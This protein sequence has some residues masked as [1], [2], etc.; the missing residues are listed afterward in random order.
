MLT[1]IPEMVALGVTHLWLPPPSQSVDD[2]G[3]LP[4]QLYNL[5]SKYG[6]REQ[7]VELCRALKAANIAPVADVVINHR[8]AEGKDEK[9]IYN[10]YG[11]DVD[12]RGRKINWGKWAVTGVSFFFFFLLSPLPTFGLT[13]SFVDFFCCPRRQRFSPAR[14]MIL[15]NICANYYMFLTLLQPCNLL[16]KLTN[17]G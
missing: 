17:K 10:V 9:G 2:R 15:F 14:V 13:F 1:K 6:T 7:L 5:N 3:Y 4:G 8:C 11:D 12:H 16:N